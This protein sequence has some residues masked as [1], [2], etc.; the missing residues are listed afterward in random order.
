M[1]DV[2]GFGADVAV[3]VAVAVS[4]ACNDC[5]FMLYA[6]LHMY[7][8]CRVSVYSMDMLNLYNFIVHTKTLNVH[9]LA[10]EMS[11]AKKVILIHTES[12][13]G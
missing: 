9:V 7:W 5:L 6:S 12:T 3:T 1:S 2:V 4:A 8:S 10:G 11:K 13:A